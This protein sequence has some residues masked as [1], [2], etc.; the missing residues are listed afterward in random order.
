MLHLPPVG[1][2]AFSHVTPIC[3][4][5][6]YRTWT[7]RPSL[8]LEDL[9]VHPDLRNRGAGKALFRALAKVAREKDCARMDWQVL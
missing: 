1:R 7:A 3:A 5:V 8:Y 4:P 9:F 6:L 2:R